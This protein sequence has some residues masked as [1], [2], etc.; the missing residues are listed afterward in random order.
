MPS[1]S[2]V[3]AAPRDKSKVS[4]ET[5]AIMD[6][7]VINGMEIIYDENQAKTMLPR[8][9]AGEDSI[10]T[11]AEILVNIVSRIVSSAKESGQTI[12]PEV[13]LHG[14]NVLFGELLKVLEAAGM[15]PLSEEQKTAVWQMFS[16]LYIDQA[17]ASG[18][19][20]KEELV[21]LS[22][23]IEQTDEGKKIIKTRENPEEAIKG[24]KKPDQ[25]SQTPQ[26][27]P[28]EVPAVSPG[29]MAA[30]QGGI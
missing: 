30:P 17:V 5:Q 11:M 25:T 14:S 24:L 16:S 6:I 22:K 1:Q 2:K 10:K 13:I 7:F 20:T 19:I 26:A 3:N 28:A 27:V 9:G 23:E 12:P 18:Q 29:A 15:E 4:A 8:I 21:M